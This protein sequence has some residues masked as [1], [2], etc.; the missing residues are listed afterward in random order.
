MCACDDD[1]RMTMFGCGCGCVRVS[2][3]SGAGGCLG[4]GVRSVQ[5]VRWVMG[6]GVTMYGFDVSGMMTMMMVSIVGA[7]MTIWVSGAVCDV[8]W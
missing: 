4:S 6:Y 1:V 5:V 2:C 7:A 8:R 3:G